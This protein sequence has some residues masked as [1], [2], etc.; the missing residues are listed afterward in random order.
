[1]RGFCLAMW[2]MSRLTIPL[3]KIQNEV[4]VKVKVNGIHNDTEQQ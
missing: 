3:Y 4:S 2:R 1:M